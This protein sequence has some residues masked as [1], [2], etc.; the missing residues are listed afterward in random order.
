MQFEQRI[1]CIEGVWDWGNREVEPSVEPILQMLRG[2]DYWNYVRRDCAT[3]E[4]F[5]HYVQGEWCKRCKVGSI[6]YIASHGYEGGI[7]LSDDQHL[8]LGQLAA[9]LE[10]GGCDGCLVHFGGCDVLNDKGKA[11]DFI[12]RT[13]AA[14]VSGYKT[15]TNWTDHINPPAVALELMLF[16]SISGEE[17]SSNQVGV[18]RKLLTTAEGLRERFEDCEFELYIRGA[19]PK[20]EPEG[21]D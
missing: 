13:G 17:I 18:R 19:R 7:S 14:A 10:P 3:T 11:F 20:S 16:S 8:D 5:R 6:L 9:L 12:K 21:L 4:E 15:E 1:Y 2:M